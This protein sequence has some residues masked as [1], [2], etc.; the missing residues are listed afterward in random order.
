LTTYKS[1]VRDN[2]IG[3]LAR[4]FEF[5]RSLAD[6]LDHLTI[7][8]TDLPKIEGAAVLVYGRDLEPLAIANSLLRIELDDDQLAGIAASLNDGDGQCSIHFRLSGMASSDEMQA[9]AANVGESLVA[10]VILAGRDGLPQKSTT[11]RVVEMAPWIATTI[12]AA[13]QAEAAARTA[14]LHA[15]ACR[16][17]GADEPDLDS[18]VHELGELFQGSACTILLEEEATKTLRLSASTDPTLG[19]NDQV[20]Y[21]KGEGLTGWV[22]ATGTSLRLPREDRETVVA[23]IGFDRE[24]PRFPEHDHAGRATTQYLGVPIRAGTTTFG[25]VR[26]SRLPETARFTI[27]DQTALE[28]FADLLGIAFKR[29][30]KLLVGRTIEESASVAIAI[31]RSEPQHDGTFVPRLIYANPGATEML[32]YGGEH[33]VGHDV[34]KL[35]P[36]GAYEADYQLLKARLH[37]TV[38]RRR[39]ELGPIDS[40]LLHKDGSPRSVKISYR[41]LADRRIRPPEIYTIGIFRER[42]AAARSQA[43]HRRLMEMLRGMGIAYFRADLD[44]KV[45]ETSEA[46]ADVLGYSENELLNLN[47]AML[48]DDPRDRTRWIDLAQR[49]AGD[50]VP[51][52]QPLR[53]HDGVQVHVEGYIR[54]VLEPMDQGR[55]SVE[56]LYRDVTQRLEIQSFVDAP[57]DRVVPDDVLFEKLR[58]REQRQHDYLSSL[59]HQL[60]T[61]LASLVGNLDDLRSGLLHEKAEVEESLRWV[62]GQ[63]KQCMRMV[64]NLSSWTRSCARSRLPRPRCRWPRSA[65]RPSSTS[66]TSWTKS[67]YISRSM[68]A[69]WTSTSRWS[70]TPT[71]C[72]R[73]LSIWSTTRSNTRAR[74]RGSRSAPRPGREGGCW[75]SP[76]QG[77]ESRPRFGRRSSSVVS[78]PRGP[79]PSSLT[80]PASVFGSSTRSS[81]RTEPRSPATRSKNGAGSVPSFA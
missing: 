13:M 5:P 23:A 3:K 51:V 63:T 26:M 21:A 65:S 41:I 9:V 62:I 12:T 55:T 36:P 74:G 56:G 11:D 18:I 24:G 37:E 60:I 54:T 34:R 25:V 71:S 73:R 8:L 42:T 59:G 76:T 14:R 80:A 46:E 16:E 35:Y 10:A 4:G 22:F 52:R 39:S 77:S 28:F 69:A 40:E 67:N 17:L 75:R 43:Q 58:E 7:A 38:E 29:T 48:Y 33:M 70:V 57:G 53:R 68:T 6:T 49:K 30:W 2:L 47:R 79:G 19:K 81:R 61:P 44:G 27:E 31:T 72:A 32:G 1:K 45:R 20:I 15:L 66:S 64:R 78:A 50:L